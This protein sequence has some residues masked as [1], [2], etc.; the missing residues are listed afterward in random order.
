MSKICAYKE[1]INLCEDSRNIMINKITNKLPYE[2]LAKMPLCDKHK[3]HFVDLLYVLFD[4][5][6]C[7]NKNCDCHKVDLTGLIK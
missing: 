7:D 2:R 4:I 5:C 1:C 6:N 3:N